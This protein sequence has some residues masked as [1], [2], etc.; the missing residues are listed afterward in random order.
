MI[1]CLNHNLWWDSLIF[2]QSNLLELKFNFRLEA[3]SVL[4]YFLWGCSFRVLWLVGSFVLQ[5]IF[6]LG[7]N[8]PKFLIH[9]NL[10]PLTF[11]YLH[12]ST[13]HHTNLPS[14][15]LKYIL[16]IDRN[17]YF[18]YV[19]KRAPFS[20]HVR[21]WMDIVWIRP[22]CWTYI[23]QDGEG[24]NLLALCVISWR[25]TEQLVQSLLLS[26]RPLTYLEGQKRIYLF[27]KYFSILKAFNRESFDFKWNFHIY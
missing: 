4:Q 7:D 2:R 3:W 17:N 13:Y 8:H 27:I 9:P 20:S 23:S 18:W 15:F 16:K 19:V 10:R 5:T 1:V 14:Y 22:Y 21:Y 6:V 11:S 12:H 25:D 24:M 26:L